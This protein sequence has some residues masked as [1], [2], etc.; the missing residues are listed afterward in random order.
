MLSRLLYSPFLVQLVVTRRC[1]ISCGYCNEYDDTSDPVPAD[2][3]RRRIDRI[4]AL[5]A[6]ALEFTGGE[7]L[8]HPDLASLI[9]Y[10]KTKRFRRV[11]LISNAFLL[12]ADKIEEFNQAG[13]DDLQVSV[14]GVTPTD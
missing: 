12:N 7:P 2:E 13:L 14:D 4:D 8:T 10:A 11:M 5:G 3:L 1:N 6:F 9:A